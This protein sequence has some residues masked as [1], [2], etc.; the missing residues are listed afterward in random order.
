MFKNTLSLTALIAHLVV[1]LAV[2]VGVQ[3][4]AI[5]AGLQPPEITP[6]P[7]QSYFTRYNFWVEKERHI[8]TNYSR[9]ELIPFNTKVTLKSIGK[10]K[11]VLDVDG[12]KIT[13]VNA[14]KHTQ[15][16][17]N[18]IAAELLSPNK[19]ALGK[20]SRDRRNDMESGTMRLGMTKEQVL[21]TR[22]Y[23]P[24]HKT[25]STKSNN[26][27][28]WS[29]RFVQLTIVFEKGKLARGRGLY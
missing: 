7:D 12:R 10:K 20:I 6:Q 2:I 25:A 16:D 3:S 9:G 5:A 21:I 26:W 4:S 28:Y 1:L 19:L 22:G 27:V 8:T 24:R 14:K 15:R 23:P 17:L 18:K 13:F 29:S 11:M